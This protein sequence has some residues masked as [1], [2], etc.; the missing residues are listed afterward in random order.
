MET[1]AP[2][3]GGHPEMVALSEA[4][5]LH[6]V[7]HDTAA[8]GAGAAAAPST[9]HYSLGDESSPA[10][11]PPPPRAPANARL[12]ASAEGRAARRLRRI[13]RLAQ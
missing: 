12:I 5:R 11:P 8:L 10:R 7:I 6:I 3:Y 4:L 1:D 2:K 13:R 9:P